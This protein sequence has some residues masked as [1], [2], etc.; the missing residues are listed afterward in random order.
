MCECIV[1]DF[2][3]LMLLMGVLCSW[4]CILNLLCS[5]SHFLG[6][7]LIITQYAYVFWGVWWVKSFYCRCITSN[8]RALPHVS[9]L[10][11]EKKALLPFGEVGLASS[12]DMVFKVVVDLVCMSISK[13]FIPMCWEI[14]IGVLFSLLVVR[15]LRFLPM[16]LFVHL[17]PLK[18]VFKHSPYLQRACLMGFPSFMHQKESLGKWCKFSDAVVFCSHLLFLVSRML[19]FNLLLVA[20]FIGG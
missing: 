13:A 9:L 6:V 11:W 10:F 15:V 17:K 16:L 7:V 3:E 8:T 5:I 14:A 1:Y 18:F 20:A 19:N 12:L 4:L 2:V